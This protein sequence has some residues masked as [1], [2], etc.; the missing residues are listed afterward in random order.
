MIQIYPAMMITLSI[1]DSLAV[2]WAKH[3]LISN[4]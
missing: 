4:L 3:S 2:A 1:I